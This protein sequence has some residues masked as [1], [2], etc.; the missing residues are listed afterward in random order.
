MIS[1]IMIDNVKLDGRLCPGCIT[2]KPEED[3]VT[4]GPYCKSCRKDYARRHARFNSTVTAA[5]TGRSTGYV[6]YVPGPRGRGEYLTPLEF[7][8]REEDGSP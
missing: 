3:F 6:V 1:S 5:L 4:S 7:F 2:V 8:S